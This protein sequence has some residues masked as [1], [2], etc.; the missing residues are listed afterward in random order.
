MS[1]FSSIVDALTRIEAK[2]DRIEAK[3]DRIEAKVNRMDKRSDKSLEKVGVGDRNPD[4][5][6]GSS[7]RFPLYPRRRFFLS[8]PRMKVKPILPPSLG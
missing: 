7:L 2:V 5:M 1:A 3:V 8:I 4:S 6:A